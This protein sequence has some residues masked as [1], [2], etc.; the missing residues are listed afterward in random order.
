[1]QIIS[2]EEYTSDND[3]RPLSLTIGVFDGVHL[4]HQSL[5]RRICS[6]S[7]TPPSLPAVVTFKQNPRKTLTPGSFAGDICTPE[8]KLG[9]LEELGVKLT[10]LIDFS[11]KFS[12]I[13]GRGFIDLLLGRRKVKLIVLGRDFRC[14]H[15]LDIGAEEIQSLAPAYGTEARIADPVM[16]GG[17]PVSSSRIRQALAAGRLAEA[18]K[19]LGRPALNLRT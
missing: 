15:G 8:E 7:L 16:D 2:W 10:V 11:E 18:E 5:I 3:N 14:G 17:F 9:I 12:K 1:M 6:P 13:D 19:L 4:G